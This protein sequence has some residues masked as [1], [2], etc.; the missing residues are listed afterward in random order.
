MRIR[1]SDWQIESFDKIANCLAG[2]RQ[3]R[4]TGELLVNLIYTIWNNIVSQALLSWNVLLSRQNTFTVCWHVTT[5]TLSCLN[6]SF[7]FY[8]GE[9]SWYY[10]LETIWCWGW[11]WLL[12]DIWLEVVMI[13]LLTMGTETAIVVVVGLRESVHYRTIVRTFWASPP[14][15]LSPGPVTPDINRSSSPSSHRK[16][17]ASLE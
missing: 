7:L 16:S 12:W 5:V 1:K 6:L 3:I 4:L 15:G 10:T 14:P 11:G 8:A 9:P 17:Q 2:F 13:I